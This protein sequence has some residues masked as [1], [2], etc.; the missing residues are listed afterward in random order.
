MIWF[1][2]DL[3]LGHASM[4]QKRGFSSLQA[5]EHTLI[6]HIN[7]RVAPTDTLYVLG[8]FSYRCTAERAQQL[9]RQIVCRQVHLL[10]GN[11]D[12]DWT[13]PEVAGT[14]V[15][16]PP[17]ANL[18]APDGRLLVL[19]HYPLLSWE[20]MR[21]GSIQLHGHIHS[22]LGQSGLPGQ[23]EQAE[24]EASSAQSSHAQEEPPAPESLTYNLHQRQ[25]GIL[26]YDVG[27]DANGYEPVSLE[28]VLAWFVGVDSQPFGM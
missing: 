23:G 24:P 15:P 13:R 11:H 10:P 1:T 14:F 22:G 25:Q 28:Q 17:I 18:K 26:R 6:R 21:R 20:G 12:K 19:C 2:A 5:M 4:A 9:R 27:V 3:H 8:D 7:I 16:E